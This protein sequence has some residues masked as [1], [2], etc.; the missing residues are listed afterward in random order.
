MSRSSAKFL[1]ISSI[2]AYKS[3][4]V[5]II[6]LQGIGLEQACAVR[7]LAREGLN[8]VFGTEFIVDGG[9]ILYALKKTKTPYILELI[10]PLTKIVL[11]NML[12]SRRFTVLTC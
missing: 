4:L 7:L 8:F 5:T 10:L 1:L 12:F 3:L 2:R 11:D 6:P 9:Y